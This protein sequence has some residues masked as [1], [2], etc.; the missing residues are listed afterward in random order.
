MA[1]SSRRRPP[2]SLPREK[3][4]LAPVR[5][6]GIKLR[7]KMSASNPPIAL[8]ERLD[9]ILAGVREVVAARGGLF[10]PL[11]ALLSGRLIRRGLRFAALLAAFR[12]G[13]LRASRLRAAGSPRPARS[14]QPRLPDGFGW[15]VRRCGWQAAGY[16]GQLRHLLAE[17]DMAA[18][19]LA[20]PQVGRILRP[21]CRM[22]AVELPA[23]LALKRRRRKPAASPDAGAAREAPA[24]REAQAARVGVSC[25]RWRTVSVAVEA[26]SVASAPAS[27]IASRSLPSAVREAPAASLWPSERV[28]PTGET[29]GGGSGR[30]GEA[31]GH[32]LA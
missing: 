23:E 5:A 3:R 10:G 22:L 4:F 11:I 16:G 6:S 26:A 17:P 21:L 12:A 19:L 28:S 29:V 18:L 9:L 27:S 14:G 8:S 25:Y 32:A 7:N 2:E 31:R 30:R 13:T 1:K 15:L 20:A 24:A